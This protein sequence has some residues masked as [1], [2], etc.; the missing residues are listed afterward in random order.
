MRQPDDLGIND[1]I[2]SRMQD[3]GGGLSMQAGGGGPSMQAGGGGPSMLA[4]GASPSKQGGGEG[5]SAM[6]PAAS[7]AVRGTMTAAGGRPA[8]M[9]AISETPGRRCPRR[10]C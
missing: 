4:L 5:P 2:Q 1:L 8:V 6:A 3:G 7:R 10:R 9:A